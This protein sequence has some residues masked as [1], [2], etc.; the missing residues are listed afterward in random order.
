MTWRV[1][2]NFMDYYVVPV[3]Y[4]QLGLDLGLNIF[5]RMKIKCLN[6]VIELIVID[7]LQNT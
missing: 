4:I 1:S 3:I 2:T 5:H 6:I 7:D